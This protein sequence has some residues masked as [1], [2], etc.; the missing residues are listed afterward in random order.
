MS[1]RKMLGETPLAEVGLL[2]EPLRAALA[3]CWVTTI[4][5]FISR[6]ASEEG[7]AGLAEAA[8]VDL[9][10]VVEARAECLEALPEDERERLESPNP[11]MEPRPGMGLVVN[12]AKLPQEESNDD[13]AS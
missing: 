12:P 11:L 13:D 4:G 2:P 6:T 8:G 10:M 5:Q 3:E 1:D 7:R 9:E